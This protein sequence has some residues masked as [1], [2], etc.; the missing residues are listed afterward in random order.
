MFLALCY[1]PED[2]SAAVLVREL[3]DDVARRGYHVTVVT[4]APSYPRGRVLDG[5]RNRWF[6]V[7]RI[8]EVRVVRTWS[9]ISPSRSN[10]A[11]L[12]HQGT[13]SA[14]ALLGALLAGRP[15]VLVCYSPPLPLGLSAWALARAWGVPWVLQLEDLH[16]DAVIAAGLLRN[17]LAIAGLRGL[18]RFLYRGATHVSV[19]AETFRSALLECGVPPEKLSVI[20]VWADP[21]RVPPLPRENAFREAHGLSGKFVVLYSGNL[22]HT[23]CLEQ[24]LEAASLLR[25]EPR[26]RLVIVGEGV[27]RPALL[28]AARARGL[29]GVLFLEYQPREAFAEMLA[30]ADVGLVTLQ[31]AAARSSLPSKTFNVMSSARPLLVVAPPDCELARLVERVGCGVIAPPGPAPA[32]AEALRRLLAMS[33]AEREAMGWRGRDELL[34]RYSRERCAAQHLALLDRVC[35][36]APEGAA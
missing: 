21:E 3:A 28:A 9:F 22:G 31:P 11:R 27:K 2:V 1:A 32:I 10:V 30:A 20:P 4:P 36:A 6:S 18:E 12:L 35:G 24:V 23:S 26:L 33:E 19:I 14:T 13:W 25:D 29:G 7:E 8:G 34:A 16:P 5:Y 15:D 17:R